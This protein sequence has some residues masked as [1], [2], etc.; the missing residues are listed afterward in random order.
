MA[1]M[2]GGR[3]VVL[4]QL[5]RDLVLR[6]DELPAAGAAADV[7]LRRELLGGKGANQAVALAQLG[8]AVTLVAVVGEDDVADDLLDQATRDGI[9]VSRV[10]RRPGALTGLIVEALDGAGRWR[11]L[12]HLPDQVLLTEADVAA[13]ASTVTDAD[14]VLVQLQ[15]PSA[16]ALAA[17]RLGR[18]A[19]RLVLLDGAPRDDEHRAGLLAAADVV[20]ADAQETH[21][22]TGVTTDDPDRL[23]AA[24]GE[25]LQAGPGLLALEVRGAGN[26]FVWRGP[27]WG[28][29]HLLVPLTDEDVVDTTGGGDALIAALTVALL[30]GD[31]PSVAARYAVAAAGGTVGHP[32]GRPD[33]TE[34]RLRDR[35]VRLERQGTNG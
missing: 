23:L 2:S 15:Q 18:R 35:M 31:P 5:A 19:G 10:V 24:A 32:G 29:G 9:D 11:Y 3:V 33:L 12:Q 25:V 27:R 4:G 30:R 6:V 14:A 13:A 28:T 16:A 7:S 34:R 20:R 17:A 26:L 8:A 22:L 1:V 21:L